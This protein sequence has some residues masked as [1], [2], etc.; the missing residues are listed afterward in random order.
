MIKKNPPM[1]NDEDYA[2]LMYLE[3]IKSM[4][5]ATV[6]GN[7]EQSVMPK[8]NTTSLQSKPLDKS[9]REAGK[10]WTDRS[11]EGGSS[12]FARAVLA[13]IGETNRLSFVCDSFAGLPP[14]NRS[15]DKRDKYWDSTT[16]L[17]VP[18]EVVALSFSQY[19]LLDS[20]V[21]FAKGFFNDTMPPLSK[22]IQK[23]AIMRLDGDMYE[24]TVDVLY[25]LYDKLSIGGFVIMDDWYLPSQDGF[26]SK[27]ACEDFFKVSAMQFEHFQAKL[28]I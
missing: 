28:C 26:P 9:L 3:V 20:N 25:N 8:L 13:A 12:I 1:D 23:L 2:R 18:S 16:Y 10:D 22:H 21:V 19:G 4:V 6:F 15:L 24:S 11:L 14:G 17:E 27:R 5:S 7:K